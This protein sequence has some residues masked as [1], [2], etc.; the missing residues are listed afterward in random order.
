MEIFCSHTVSPLPLYDL[1][2]MNIFHPILQNLCRFCKLA[3]SC[4]LFEFLHV[5]VMLSF[6]ILVECEIEY[7][8]LI[9]TRSPVFESPI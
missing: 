1:S 6:E 8:D 3:L 2:E 7:I 4:L 5:F 9:I